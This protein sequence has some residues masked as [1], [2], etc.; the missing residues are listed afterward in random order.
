MRKIFNGIAVS[1]GVVIGKA[2]V[3]PSE[4]F[5]VL[6]RL[7]K[8][9]DINN[10]IARFKS[11]IEKAKKEIK[12]IQVKVN[13]EIG[14][15]HS[16]IFAAHLLVLEDPSLTVEVIKAIKTTKT[17]SEYIFNNALIKFIDVL[18]K[19]D[20]EYLRD[21]S[22]DIRDI[23]KRVLKTLIGKNKD[24]LADLQEEV[25]IFARDLSPTDTVTMK[26]DKVK[27]FCTD[28]GGKT[29]HT[30]IMARALEIPAVVALGNI[31]SN[32]QTGDSVI[33]D[34]ISGTVIVD[35]SEEDLKQYNKKIEKLLQEEMELSKLRDLSAE[36]MDGFKINL[37]ANIEIQDE[38]K[39]VLK[40]GA[41]GIGLFRTEFLFLN[42]VDLPTEEEQFNAYFSA[43]EFLYPNQVIIRTLDLGGDK[44]LS[45]LGLKKED[46]PFLGLRAIRL[47]LAKP[48]FFKTQLRAIL[49]A[50]KLKN[51]KIMFPMISG[52]EE[53][54]EAAKILN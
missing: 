30:A 39:L 36:T 19:I 28:I 31:S 13:K 48:D 3:L 27:G 51:M 9:E 11:A 4:E 12:E 18:S 20:D 8:D 15:K 10:E 45:N 49:R 26:R 24:T 50:S 37:N 16:N 21:K 29:S 35:P 14:S 22:N 23:G 47:C 54:K 25:I 1:S 6:K 2:L 32:V 38:V 41:S 34:G 40:H 42:R 7:L 46:N 44:F 33:V 52:V 53:F 17:N 5:L 43:T